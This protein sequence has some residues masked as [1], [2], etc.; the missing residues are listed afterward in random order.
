[1]KHVSLLRHAKAAPAGVGSD[2]FIRPLSASG[3]ADATL[4]GETTA[5][6]VPDLILSSPSRRTTETV[7][8][9]CQTWPHVPEIRYDPT[10]Y[11]AEW[12]KILD[13][14]RDLPADVRDV[15]IV[16]HN[17]GLHELAIEFGRYCGLGILDS[18]LGRHFP[19]AARASF[20]FD[21]ASW[22]GILDG[23]CRLVALVTPR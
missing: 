12:D 14:L 8:L 5:G 16:G 2:D 22:A 1:M 19:T 9:V 21:S 17:P 3:R 13:K 11:L 10:L 18:A 15:W 7:E 23:K 6:L 4:V 20:S